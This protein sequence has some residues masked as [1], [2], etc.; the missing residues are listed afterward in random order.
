ME[1]IKNYLKDKKYGFYISAAAILFSIVTLVVYVCIYGQG[2]REN[3]DSMSW[4]AFAF[5][6]VGIAGGM[7]LIIFKQYNFA[8]AALALFN[9]LAFVFFIYGIYPYVS[10]VMVGIDL[11]EYSG[12][13]WVCTILFLLTV[14]TSCVSVFA[15]QT[16]HA[17]DN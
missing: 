1:K 3:M 14:I 13:F 16:K 5:I 17:N 8:S 15:K 4:W 9:F 6:M 12:A 7:T 11:E 10:V 2:P